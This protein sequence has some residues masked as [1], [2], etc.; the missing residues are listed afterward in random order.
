MALNTSRGEGDV[1]RAQAGEYRPGYMEAHSVSNALGTLALPLARARERENR[2]GEGPKFEHLELEA[3]SVDALS[4]LERAGP[5]S[6]LELAQTSG[7][8]PARVL[9]LLKAW[10]RTV[11]MRVE[12]VFCPENTEVWLRNERGRDAVATAKGKTNHHKYWTITCEHPGGL[13]FVGGISSPT[14]VA[15]NEL[16]QVRVI[17][18]PAREQ[19]SGFRKTRT[20][21]ETLKEKHLQHSVGGARQVAI[22]SAPPLA[23]AS[24]IGADCGADL[25]PPPDPPGRHGRRG[26][27][28]ALH[29]DSRPSPSSSVLSGARGGGGSFGMELELMACRWRRKSPRDGH[30]RQ[31]PARPVGLGPRD[32]WGRAPAARPLQ[33][34]QTGARDAASTCSITGS[35]APARPPPARPRPR[36]TRLRLGS[37]TS[38][39]TRPRR[40]SILTDSTLSMS[41]LETDEAPADDNA[42]PGPRRT[43][44]DPARRPRLR[45][46][47][48]GIAD[49][50]MS[51]LDAGATSPSA[52]ETEDASDEEDSGGL[53]DAVIAS[54]AD[55]ASPMP[56]SPTALCAHPKLAAFHAPGASIS[57]QPA[58]PARLAPIL[59][60]PKCS[61]YFVEPMKWMGAFL[62]GGADHGQDRVP[63]QEVRRQAR[64]LDWGFCINRSKVD[65]VVMSIYLPR[66]L[67]Q[68]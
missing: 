47:V 17:T 63:D 60:N 49:L 32:V 8:V 68:P 42:N 41:A 58:R 31:V 22:T 5:W 3:V 59:V 45:P 37:A 66:G 28:R 34:V 16:N 24:G 53:S 14:A 20:H 56:T 21:T 39:S 27:P 15:A 7:L 48:S 4:G 55:T 50:T 9:K 25:Y 35:S 65:E 36:A 13:F 44:S 52:L 26:H 12:A 33:D 43:S 11:R 46:L 30:V 67:Y 61:G 19:L 2:A 38:S 51:A 62:E 54:P 18:Y 29:P 1:V 6:S 10:A 23:T 57:P 64:Q 40:P